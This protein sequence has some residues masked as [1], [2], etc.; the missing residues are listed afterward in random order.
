[1]TCE[2]LRA[3][4]TL[5]ALGILDDPERT[6]ITEHLQRRCES[7]VPEIASALATVTAMAGAVKIVEAPRD[8]RRRIAGMVDRRGQAAYR[9]RPLVIAW[10]LSAAL[11]MALIAWQLRSRD[12]QDELARQKADQ[13]DRAPVPPAEAQLR[14]C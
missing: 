7:C 9:T 6:E 4:C 2:E 11:A 10:G 8:L 14:K 3:S 13:G 12:C 1:M 5:Y